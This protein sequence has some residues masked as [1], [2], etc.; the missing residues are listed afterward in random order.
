MTTV[1]KTTGIARGTLYNTVRNKDELLVALVIDSIEAMAD[2]VVAKGDG[3]LFA[4]IQAMG[5][6]LANDGLVASLR[7]SAAKDARNIGWCASESIASVGRAGVARVMAAAG[8]ASHGDFDP[9]VE[10]VFRWAATQ[11]GLP[12]HG[13]HLR[14]SA[15]LLTKACQ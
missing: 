6:A 4:S 14:A 9:R 5:E 15:V 13:E 3:D 7:E 2:L 1:L 11:A 8:C 12:L 10:L